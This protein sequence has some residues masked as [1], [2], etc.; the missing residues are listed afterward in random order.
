VRLPLVA[1]RHT[2]RGRCTGR[3]FLDSTP[4]AVCH[5]ARIPQQRVVAL[6]AARGKTS[7]GGFYGCNRPLVVNA[8]GE[9]R[10]CGLTRGPIADRQ[11]V[12]AWLK[13]V[14]G[15]FGTLVGEKGSSSQ[16]LAEQLL[17]APGVHRITRVRTTMRHRLL[18]LSD[19]LLLRQRALIETIDDPLK[20]S[21]QIA[22][23]RHRSPVTCLVH[24]V[25]GLIASCHQPKKPSLHMDTAPDLW[26]LPAA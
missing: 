24:L 20:T 26:A 13:R 10:A 16:P 6:E 15:L 25:C 2:P 3:S 22:H 7:V 19:T 14:P 17:G 21:C 8:R 18:P 4:R 1:D 5:T 12:A 23:T 9:V 11:P